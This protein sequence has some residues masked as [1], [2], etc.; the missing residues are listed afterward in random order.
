MWNEI[1]LIIFCPQAKLMENSHAW[2]GASTSSIAGQ[3]ILQSS[4]FCYIHHP[5]HSGDCP[6][7]IFCFY[8][9][10][11]HAY[12]LAETVPAEDAR[13]GRRDAILNSDVTQAIFERRRWRNDMDAISLGHRHDIAD[14]TA[15]C[16]KIAW[17]SKSGDRVLSHRSRTTQLS[18][19]ASQLNCRFTTI[20]FGMY[21]NFATTIQCL[22]KRAVV[23]ICTCSIFSVSGWNDVFCGDM[24]L[25]AT[26]KCL[27]HPL[28][29]FY[30]K[31]NLM[32]Y[33]K[34]V[35]NC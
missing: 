3:L 25:Y 5:T 22:N 9:I 10:S 11:I 7:T 16:W 23:A 28:V 15:I 2:L 18:Q 33:F 4:H 20:P 26:K 19:I 21:C 8:H 30:R 31:H 6:E 27:I 29:V 32:N 17:G 24:S 35:K 14:N 1:N 34:I 13:C 12:F